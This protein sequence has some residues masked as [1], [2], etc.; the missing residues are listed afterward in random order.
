MAASLTSFQHVWMAKGQYQEHGAAYVHRIFQQADDDR[1]SNASHRCGTAPAA[2][3]GLGTL[4]CSGPVVTEGQLLRCCRG[5]KLIPRLQTEVNGFSLTLWVTS[6][7]THRPSDK[8][9]SDR[10]A[11]RL[12][13]TLRAQAGH[14][15]SQPS[16]DAPGR[17]PWAPRAPQQSVLSAGAAC[18][19]QHR[20]GAA[21]A[22]GKAP[23]SSQ[24][25]RTPRSAGSHSGG[26]NELMR[27]RSTGGN[28]ATG[29]D[30]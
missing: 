18:S 16:P 26:R 3:G 10:L 20:E 24:C 2:G 29:G 22:G 14:S 6:A 7:P 28:L 9:V 23:A 21:S 17:R 4:P 13:L 12:R 1:A 25:S 19:C 8:R 27:R 30:F 5:E 11:T 15:R